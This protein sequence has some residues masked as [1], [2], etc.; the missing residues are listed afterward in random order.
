MGIE[1]RE[2]KKCSKRRWTRRRREK[3][4]RKIIEKRKQ[5]EN[6]RSPDNQTLF[7]VTLTID[8]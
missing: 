2:M 8:T 4:A 6:E 3:R 5:M 1:E 7:T